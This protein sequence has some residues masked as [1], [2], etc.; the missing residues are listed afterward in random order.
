M[1][2]F[3][4]IIRPFDIFEDKVRIQLSKT[5][6][7]YA[8]ISGIGIVLFFRGV[9][10]IFDYLPYFSLDNY[11]GGGWTTLILSLILLLST[12]T[13]VS[14]NLHDEVI[15]SGIKKEKKAMEMTAEELRKEE[16]EIADI[17]E[18]LKRIEQILLNTPKKKD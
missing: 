18:R 14:H 15:V 7:I 11:A 17:K 1:S 13:F 3:K 8:F 9:W 5:P 6:I 2:I 12:G 16:T 4:K 10:H